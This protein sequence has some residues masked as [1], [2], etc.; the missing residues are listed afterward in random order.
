MHLKTL[1]LVGFK[2]FADRTRLV[3]EPGVTVVVGPNGSGK[4]NLVDAIAWVMGTQATKALRSEKMDDLIFAG[5]AIRPSHGRAEVSLTFDNESG[6]LPIDLAEVTVTRRLH[7]DGT[8]DYEINGTPCRLLDIQEL[9]SDGGIGRHQ[10]VI[11]GQG[12]VG[13]VLNAN[14]EEHRA[15]IEEAAGVIKH[16]A[17]RD[18]SIRRLEATDIDVQ[19]LH[20]LLGE[21]R[22]LMRPLKRQANAA[23]RFDSVK[24]EWRGLRLWLGGERLR[25]TDTRLAEI[26]S[27]RRRHSGEDLGLP[28]QRLAEIAAGMGDLQA[29]AGEAGQALERDTASA[30]RLETA[31]E[32]LQRIAMVAGERRRAMQNS[33]EQADGRRRDLETERL[34]IEARLRAA[35]DEE[36]GPPPVGRAPRD[37][38]LGP[39]RRRALPGWP[40]RDAGRGRRRRGAGRSGR[41]RGSRSSRRP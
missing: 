19:R 30:A 26:A 2:S 16:R 38:P 32:R 24:A 17:R 31:I 15:I 1:S 11:V 36:V 3:F 40:G 10:H 20:D 37:R 9:L 27:R 33:L 22:R 34:D 28:S 8:S 13:A 12:R 21:Q 29:A 4:S 23:E 39:R 41:P 7:R 14:P 6:G 18:R 5:T 25:A 35:T